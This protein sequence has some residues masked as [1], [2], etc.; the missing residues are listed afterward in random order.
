MTAK[1]PAKKPA[2]KK[3]EKKMSYSELKS[4]AEEL[5]GQVVFAL[6]FLDTK[7][8]GGMR[9]DFKTQTATVWQED[10]MDSLDK[11]G[12]VVDRKAY[13]AGKNKKSRKR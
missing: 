9:F 4:L 5:A 2:K 13:W 1:K 7:G 12:Y 6:K 3:P 8:G 10:F 11:C